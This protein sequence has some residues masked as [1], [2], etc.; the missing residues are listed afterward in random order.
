VS[1]RERLAVLALCL[2]A[3]LS[4][5]DLLTAINYGRMVGCHSAAARRPL[6]TNASL[7]T[8]AEHV[9]AGSSLRAAMSATGNLA[10]HTSLMH[11]SGSVGDD[12]LARSLSHGYCGT[13]ADADFREIGAIRR[14]REVWIVLASPTAAVPHAD[15]L[16]RYRREIVEL[17]NHARTTAR[18]CGTKWYPAV[19]VL[20]QNDALDAA[21]WEHS[22]DMARHGEF[23]HRGHDGSTPV[24]RVQRAGYGAYRIVG[25]NIA[26]GPLSSAEV[27]QG[28]LASAHHCEN[29]MD[30]RFEEIGI[31]FAVNPTSSSGIYWTQDFASKH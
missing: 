15:Q 14:G 3:P 26:A 10:E 11:L 20:R 24:Q 28:W 13:L 1:L 25:E 30:A 17:V 22:H 19:P 6:R 18:R 8:V 5:A 7:Q 23:D 16:P 27:V 9:A 4:H 12:A 21:A 31:A 2:L 29:I